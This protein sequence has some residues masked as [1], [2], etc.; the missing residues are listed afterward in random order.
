MYVL[1]L[2]RFS[3]ILSVFLKD[4]GWVVGL[5]RTRRGWFEACFFFSRRGRL[6]VST[7]HGILEIEGIHCTREMCPEELLCL[8]VG[9]SLKHIRGG[10]ECHKD[11][12][13]LKIE[14][15]LRLRMG[16]PSSHNN[17]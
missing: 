10:A 4:L 9:A 15:D 17:D 6:Q 16:L 1:E 7:T 11:Q 2:A 13:C 8:E 14:N 5:T 12:A 3:R